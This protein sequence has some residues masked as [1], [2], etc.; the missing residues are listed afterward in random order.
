MVRKLSSVL[1][2]ASVPAWAA[3][4]RKIVEMQV[5][6]MA[7]SVPTSAHEQ[8]HVDTTA[9]L[10]AACPARGRPG[11]GARGLAASR[12]RAAPDPRSTQGRGARALAVGH[13][14]TNEA[15]ILGLTGEIVSPMSKGA[16]VLVVAEAD[17]ARVEPLP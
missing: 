13:S 17:H 7:S 14:P 5:I 9:A 1:A 15:A 8:P 2:A 12:R 16:G 11:A 10:V 4:N 6:S 3:G